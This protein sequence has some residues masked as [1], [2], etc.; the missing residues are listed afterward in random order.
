MTRTN[1]YPMKT[2]PKDGTSV[3]IDCFE[4][5]PQPA[6]YEKEFGAWKSLITEKFVSPDGWFPLPIKCE[7]TS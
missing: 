7:V 5:Y 4:G 6:Y 1:F 3:L 2:A